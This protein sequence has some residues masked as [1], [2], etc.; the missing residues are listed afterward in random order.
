[1]AKWRIELETTVKNV[2]VPQTDQ[3]DTYRL[4][5]TNV[6][7]HFG[8]LY[9]HMDRLGEMSRTIMDEI[10]NLSLTIQILAKMQ[11]TNAGLQ[12]SCFYRRGESPY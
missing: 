8:I 3:M 2:K 11:F 5:H 4:N 6:Q 1:M 12:Q 10:M 7:R 9:C